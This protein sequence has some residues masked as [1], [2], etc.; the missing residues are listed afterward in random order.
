[1]SD[2]DSHDLVSDLRSGDR[3][4]RVAAIHRAAEIAGPTDN[5]VEA[6]ASCLSSPDKL[7]QRRAAEALAQLHRAHVP[8]EALLLGALHASDARFRWGA[9]FALSLL[10][11]L[12]PAVRPILIENLGVDDGD[13]RWAAA[14]LLLQ[15]SEG[16]AGADDLCRL[17][18]EGNS[19]QRKMSAYC[20]R[21]LEQRSAAVQA[22][23]SKAVGDHD[24]GV[25]LAAVAALARLPFDETAAADG[26]AALLEDSDAGV[27]RAAAAA[28]GQLRG[29]SAGAL[30]ALRR[31][32]TSEDDS[33]RR[34]A[35]GALGK[36][37]F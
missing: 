37:G 3:A 19:N 17:L 5:L 4:R 27:R 29:L 6:L 30:T 21:R 12:A 31:A 14:D 23:L 1:M 18:R 35:A 16:F 11:P 20:L 33:L 13:V 22:A 36:L 24:V 9:A 25:R 32:A 15:S 8:V 7:I 10:G 34:A 2:S 26:I 28:L